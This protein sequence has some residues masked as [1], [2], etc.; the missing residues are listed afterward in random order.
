VNLLGAV[1]PAS[2][3]GL[4]K[5]VGFLIETP[6]FLPH[7]NAVENLRCHWLLQGRGMSGG[8]SEIMECLEM[9]GLKAAAHR[10]V[11]GYS[12]GMNQRL[13]LAQAFL[14]DPELIVLDEPLS[15]LDP[16]GILHIRELI[17][18]WARRRGTTF[19]ISSHILAEVEQLCT[20]VGFVAHGRTV[21]EGSLDELGATGW[22]GI[23]VSDPARAAAIIKEK[24]PGAAPEP[25]REGIL[26]L[27]LDEALIP[28]LVRLLVAEK[29]DV[30]HA[31]RKPKSLEEVFME[32]TGGRP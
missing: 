23:R 11:K 9:V 10:P 24:W 32:L 28:E 8:R 31:G 20:R 22:V 17:R 7:L 25:G 6:S 16:E 27:R 14:G 26:S 1:R 19:F 12:T 15:G 2:D 3:H 30:H 29:L 5:R 13:G 4:R 21:A 18:D